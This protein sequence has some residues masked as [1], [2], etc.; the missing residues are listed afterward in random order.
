MA[1]TPLAGKSGSVRWGSSVGTVLY[2]SEW[3][4]SVEA[5]IIPADT[6]EKTASNSQYFKTGLVGLIGGEATISG[7]WENAS[8]L[9]YSGPVILARAGNLLRSG[10]AATAVFLGVSTTVGFTVTGIIKR[11][12]PTS[13][14]AAANMFS[15]SVFV[16]DVVYTGQS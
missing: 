3:N 2:F 16:E 11:I 9:M 1:F 12:N 14:V 13:N 7:L 15:F 5:D 6:F 10:G 8:S 4:L